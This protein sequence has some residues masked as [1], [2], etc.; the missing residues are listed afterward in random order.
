M[1]SNGEG[2]IAD[3]HPDGESDSTHPKLHDAGKL[4]QMGKSKAPVP[5]VNRGL[6]GKAL[7]QRDRDVEGSLTA[8]AGW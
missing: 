1:V 7:I 6:E 3:R 4:A 8:L 2:R 5:G